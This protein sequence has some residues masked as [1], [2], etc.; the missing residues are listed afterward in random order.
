LEGVVD[1]KMEK[2]CAAIA[3][4]SRLLPRGKVTRRS[5]GSRN[6]FKQ[7]F[8]PPVPPFPLEGGRFLRII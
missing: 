3:R 6:N 4:I 8:R 2:P 5:V 1:V 7:T